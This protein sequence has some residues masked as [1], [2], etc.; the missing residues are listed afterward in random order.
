[1]VSL[2]FTDPVATPAV[3][4]PKLKISQQQDAGGGLGGLADAAGGLLGGGQGP[5]PWSTHLLYMRMSLALGDH[6]DHVVLHLLETDSAPATQ[7]GDQLD[8]ALGYGEDSETLL[9]TGTIQ[10]ME[11]T[12]AGY[13]RLIVTSPLLELAQK[14]LNS[15]FEEQSASD[16]IQAL[17]GETEV[18][19]GTVDS[20][21]QYPFFVVSDRHSLLA[22]I[23]LIAQQQNWL[24][25]CGPDGQLNARAI[26]SESAAKTFAYGVDIIDLQHWT[27]NP[28]LA[29]VKVVGGG[30]A[31]SNGSDAWNWLTKEPKAMSEAGDSS[32]VVSLRAL[33]DSPGTQNHA[34]YL[35]AQSQSATNRVRLQTSA[36]PEVVIGAAFEITGAPDSATNGIFVADRVVISFDQMQGFTSIIEGFNRDAAG[37]GGL[38]ALGGLL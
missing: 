31:T 18:A 35:M 26:G 24:C 27:Q 37:A 1:M 8:V 10:G 36:A 2:P 11:T 5:D 38:G 17:L 6:V 33:R 29:G 23:Q 32:Q 13:R 20:G 21:E 30:A 34:D 3:V 22:H 15:S 12:L 19:A 25:F 14:R 9:F 16:I 4:A 7:L 28:A